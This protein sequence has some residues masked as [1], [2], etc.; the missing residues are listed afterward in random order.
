LELKKIFGITK[1][2]HA[3]AVTIFLVTILIIMSVA[4]ISIAPQNTQADLISDLCKTYGVCTTSSPPPDSGTSSPGSSTSGKFFLATFLQYVNKDSQV[5]IYKPNMGSEDMTRLRA[6]NGAIKSDYVQ[7]SL[8]LPGPAGVSFISSQE[9]INNAKKVK[10]LGFTFVEFN[11]ESGLSPDSDNNNVVGAMKNAAQAAHQQGLK[12][13]A[14][15]SRGYTTNY[16]SQIA[17]FSDY[18]HIQ[19]QSLQQKGVK[20]YSDY[21][22]TIVSKL[23]QANSN[24]KITVQVSTKQGSAP[25][26]S[27]LATL[28][29]CTASV[30][31]VVHGASLWFG[32]SDLSTV[33]SYTQWY[34]TKY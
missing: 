34:N 4:S 26:L 31:D 2:Y 6:T 21:V 27:L 14:A 9:I 28:E 7:S 22:H 8:S 11:L 25:G 32:N 15:P 17:P 30:M 1:G 13:L 29:Q 23:K 16:G 19:A 10:D 3:T 5:N 12:F 24:V 18:Y 33:K 20:A